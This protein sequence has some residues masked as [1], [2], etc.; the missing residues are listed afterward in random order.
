[1]NRLALDTSSLA[2]SVA[3]S[4]NDSVLGRHEEQSREHTRLLMPMIR[5]LLGEAGVSLQE[6]DGIVLGN[7]PGSFIGMRIAAS[8]AQGLAHGAGLRILP[9]SSLAAVALRAGEPGDVVAV[10]QDAHMN[11]VYLGVYEVLSPE[12]VR[13]IGGET[14][15]PQ[16]AIAELPDCIA[17]GYGWQRYPAL[18]EQNQGA[19]QHVS[20]VL[21]PDARDLLRL[22]GPLFERDAIAPEDVQPAYL[23]QKVAEK[24][25]GENRNASVT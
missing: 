23:R 6:L 19:V 10:A 1:M 17:A 5:E 13:A 8:V 7:G 3:I 11:E 14:L 21:Y 25:G 24:P 18:L 15:Q 12:A 9:L 4:V 2:C 22:A 20:D 16:A